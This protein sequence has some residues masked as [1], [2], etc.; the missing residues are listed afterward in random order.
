MFLAYLQLT[1][2]DGYLFDHVRFYYNG[3]TLR[4][5]WYYLPLHLSWTFL[6]DS[7]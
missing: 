3:V 1:L 5:Y 4:H 2:M 6:R 7:L